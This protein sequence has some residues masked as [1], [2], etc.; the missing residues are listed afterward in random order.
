MEFADRLINWYEKNKRDLPWRHTTDPYKIWLSEII[1]QQTRVQQGLP[2]YEKFVANFPT[3]K[4]FAAADIDKVLHLWQGLGYYSRARNMHIAANEVM[5]KWN[6]Q[7]PDNYKDLLTL[8]GVGK[9]TAAAIASFGFK[10]KVATVDGNVYRVL[11]RIFD[12]DHDI[13]SGKGQKVFTEVANELISESSP[14]IFNQALMEMGAIQ[15]TPKS[16]RCEDCP[17]VQECEARIKDIISIRPVKLKKVK[18]SNRYLQ[19][20][21]IEHNGRFILKKRAEGDIWTGL[22]DFP[23]SETADKPTEFSTGIILENT[24]LEIHENTIF[25]KSETFKHLLSHRKLFIE[26]FHVK[27]QT[28]ISIPDK[29][30]DYQWMDI[31]EIK[32]VGKPIILENYLTK[33]IY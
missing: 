13:A 20:F 8:K 1:L 3:V 5:E 19:Y 11:S 7:F 31:E 28:Q 9:Y 27:L 6:G 30:T 16:P 23:L 14:D 17:F 22:Y 10:E 18:V 33:Y 29:H 2:Y 24:G 25:H 21:V 15:C 32:S 26:F 12:I 4:D